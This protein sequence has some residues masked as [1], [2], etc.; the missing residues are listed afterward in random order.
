MTIVIAL[1]VWLWHLMAGPTNTEEADMLNGVFTDP[2]YAPPSTRYIGFSTTTPLED[3]TN[4]TEPSGNN[5]SRIATVAADWDAATGGAPSTKKNGSA[6]TS[7]TASGSW[8]TLTHMGIFD[9]ASGG[10]PKWWA[11]LTSSKAVGS[12]DTAQ[13]PIQALV[14]EL[15]DPADSY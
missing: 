4:F 1:L 3:G 8:S 14:L 11:A 5:Y 15:G 13:F 10:S 9:A 2:A 7:P 6:I 12:G